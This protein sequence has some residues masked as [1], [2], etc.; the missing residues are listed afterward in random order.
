MA[1]LPFSVDIANTYK[2]FGCQQEIVKASSQKNRK[3]LRRNER[4][5][6]VLTKLR[7]GYLLTMRSSERPTTSVPYPGIPRP[8][9]L[10]LIV[11]LT[12]SP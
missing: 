11:M 10:S 9:P 2:A 8:A 5:M 1:R 4:I 7:C 3:M 6:V 12:F